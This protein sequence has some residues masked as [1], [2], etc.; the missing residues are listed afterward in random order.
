M[1]KQIT[2]QQEGKILKEAMKEF[3]VTSK[4]LLETIDTFFD[5]KTEAQADARKKET[6]E[7][8][9]ELWNSEYHIG[10]ECVNLNEDRVDR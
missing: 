5:E 7:E 6:C 4:T 2:T 1:N 9:G 8:C 3:R 10:D